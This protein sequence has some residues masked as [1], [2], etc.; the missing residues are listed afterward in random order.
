MADRQADIAMNPALKELPP[1]MPMFLRKRRV[2]LPAV[3]ELMEELDLDGDRDAFFT[4]AQLHVA[5]GSY[6]GDSITPA[7]IKSRSR[8]LYSTVDLLERPLSVLRE[9]GLVVEDGDGAIS[10][11]YRARD[12]VE[13]LNVAGR[14]HV[15]QAQP[16]PSDELEM[17]TSQLERAVGSILNDPVL[18][19]RPGSH[20]A[21]SRSLATLGED[22]PLMVRLEQAIYDLWM[23][24][25]D[26][27]IK[28]WRDAGLEGPP[29][30]A[31]TLIWSGEASTVSGLVEM[32]HADRSPEDVES[33]L[34]YL[35]D[36]DFIVRVGDDLQLTPQGVLV[37]EDIERDTDLIYFAS[38]PH[39]QAEAEWMRDKLRELI[40]NLPTPQAA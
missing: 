11:T 24:R 34:V 22:A 32:L 16:L 31:L 30:Q 18:A 19:P 4:L 10:L 38:W 14:A 25:D 35:L 8:Y 29:M 6:G 21:G 40:D 37:R 27:H 39:T 3:Q 2:G 13:R 5:Q 7:Q 33:S 9:K 26:A 20:L 15:A 36:R 23:A 12:A 28:A 17:L 1:L